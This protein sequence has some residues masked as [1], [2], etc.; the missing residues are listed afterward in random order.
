MANVPTYKKAG[1]RHNMNTLNRVASKILGWI[2]LC[3]LAIYLLAGIGFF[4]A[5]LQDRFG[6]KHIYARCYEDG[7]EV[8][9]RYMDTN[10]GESHV[11]RH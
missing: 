3:I 11:V 4:F 1:G 9:Y 5:G 6:N 10:T 7:K 2:V 8:A